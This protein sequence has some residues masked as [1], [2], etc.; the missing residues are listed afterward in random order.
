MLLGFRDNKFEVGEWR[1][2]TFF[3]SA[4]VLQR[5]VKLN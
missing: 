3:I 4:T 1:K 2:G 5:N